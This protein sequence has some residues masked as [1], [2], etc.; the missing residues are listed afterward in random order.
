MAKADEPVF[1][2]AANN[3]IKVGKAVGEQVVAG[4]LIGDLGQDPNK[5]HAIGHSMGGQVVGNVG[6][7]AF[8]FSSQKIAR[9]TGLDVAQQYFDSHLAEDT[10][11]P[12]DAKL[13]DIMHTNR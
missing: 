5:I 3:A 12:N 13:V 11:S 1:S 6:K 4:M 2:G 7:A 8:Q 9:V 10:I